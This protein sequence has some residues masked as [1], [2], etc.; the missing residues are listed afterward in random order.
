MAKI[1]RHL[2]KGTTTASTTFVAPLPTH[3]TDDLILVHINQNGDTQVAATAC[4]NG[5]AYTINTVG[6]TDF[7]AIGASANTVGVTFTATGAGTG[8]G[9]C[10]YNFTV[11]GGWTIHQQSQG[12]QT[13]QK[14]R[15]AVIY[16]IAASSSETAPTITSNI[17]DEWFAH[18]T[19]ISGADTTTPLDTNKV[20][21]ETGA[22]PRITNTAITPTNNE[23][24]VIDAIFPVHASRVGIA[25]PIPTAGCH[26]YFA[27]QAGDNPQLAGVSLAW[28]YLKT[29]AASA[30]MEWFTNNGGDYYLRSTIAINDNGDADRPAYLDIGTENARMIVAFSGVRVTATSDADTDYRTT[31]VLNS[32]TEVY[33]ALKRTV[34]APPSLG[35][36]DATYP[37]KHGEASLVNGNAGTGGVVIYGKK[38]ASTKDFSW[39]SGLIFGTYRTT[40]T[41]NPQYMATAVHGGICCSVYDS[42][43]SPRH[44]RAW[45]IGALDNETHP[46]EG[47][48]FLVQTNIAGTTEATGTNGVAQ[49]A[50]NPT[51]STIEAFG[52]FVES[53]YTTVYLAV[54]P[55]MLLN[56][57]VV[58]GGSTADPVDFNDFRQLFIFAQTDLCD[59]AGGSAIQ[60]YIPITFGGGEPLV[61]DISGVSIAFPKNYDVSSGT[62]Y[63]NTNVSTNTMGITFDGNTGDVI[64]LRNSLLSSS[65]KWAFQFASGAVGTYDLS[66]TTVS[67]AGT[68]TLRDISQDLSGVTFSE[69]DEITLNSCDLDS[70]TITGS[71]AASAMA[72]VSATECSGLTNLDF[73]NNT[74]GHSITITTAGTYTFDNFTFTGGGAAA[75]STADV[76]NNSGGAVTINVTN[77]GST[78]TIKNGTSASTTVNNAVT[79]TV[80]A[81]DEAGSPIQNARVL[82]EKTTG[83]AD[84]LTG[85]TDA[86]GIAT[87]TYAYTAD[88]ALTG[89][90]RKSSSAPYYKQAALAG[91]LT[92]SGFTATVVMVSDD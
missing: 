51:L 66:G 39:G 9:T 53:G 17:S 61:M 59:T 19:I 5:V 84:V 81:V 68:V 7:T 22:S 47:N 88:A 29:A 30:A 63:L 18:T 74:S 40:N 23:S 77:G 92:S 75:S 2:G 71:T 87:T 41:T 85:L 89:W 82:L 8:T 4:T 79:V 55:A 26:F 34:D 32:K 20:L 45:K 21:T 91:T 36:F 35:Q 67:N 64:K 49:S 76:Y 86:S 25:E 69:C 80:T 83:G 28:Q 46:V 14:N 73:I 12:L 31:V 54:H 15:C 62:P 65:H 57:L 16:K 27:D 50:T 78:P 90:V 52:F 43:T 72:I 6:S 24:L 58:A 3:A 60:S 37:N 56:K 42:A 10:G 1:V 13:S 44:W 70:C 48:K 38:F 33:N 11:T